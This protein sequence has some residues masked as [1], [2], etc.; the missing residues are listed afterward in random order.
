METFNEALLPSGITNLIKKMIKSPIKAGI[1]IFLIY[2]IL[3]PHL[4]KEKESYIERLEDVQTQMD[5]WTTS[6]I[7]YSIKLIDHKNLGTKTLDFTGTKK[8]VLKQA[9]D[10]F[11]D[12]SSVQIQRK[13]ATLVNNKDLT[14]IKDDKILMRKL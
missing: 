3:K 6:K 14:N 4:N 10:Y 13:G 8:H 7:T 2:Q 12:A 5:N 1:A 11:K 9:R